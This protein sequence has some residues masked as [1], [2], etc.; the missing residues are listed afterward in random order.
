LGQLCL[1]RRQVDRAVAPRWSAA[2]GGQG[3]AARRSAGPAFRRGAVAA[4]RQSLALRSLAP[5]LRP[6]RVRPADPRT[7]LRR[8]PQGLSSRRPPEWTPAPVHRRVNLASPKQFPGLLAYWAFDEGQGNQVADLSGNGQDGTIH[9]GWWID[10]VGGGK[11]LMFD[12]KADFFD[13]GNDP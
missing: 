4:G 2:R 11:A 6:G 13:W 12:G 3:R 10:G 8:D 1:A 7:A 9:G 5:R